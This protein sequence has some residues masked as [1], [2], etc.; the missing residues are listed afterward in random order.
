MPIEVDD[1]EVDSDRIIEF[2][3]AF[4]TYFRDFMIARDEL[5]PHVLHHAKRKKINLGGCKDQ[6]VIV[7]TLGE[8]AMNF[9]TLS[10]NGLKLCDLMFGVQ[11][12]SKQTRPWFVLPRQV[13]ARLRDGVIG[14]AFELVN[15]MC[16]F[17]VTVNRVLE[18]LGFCAFFCRECGDQTVRDRIGSPDDMYC[19]SCGRGEVN[20][21]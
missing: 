4:S 11:D 21:G 14:E 9:E 15:D 16:S 1:I 20:N 2:L 17:I 8:C 18:S 10:R 3:N 13:A 12:E 19:R 7:Q 5:E 6:R